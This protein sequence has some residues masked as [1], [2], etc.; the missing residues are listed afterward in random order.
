MLVKRREM[1]RRNDL[2]FYV[3]FEVKFNMSCVV[4]G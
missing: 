1:L 3:V 2:A 4:D